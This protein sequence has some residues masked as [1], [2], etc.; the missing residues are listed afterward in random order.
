MNYYDLIRG[1]AFKKGILTDGDVKTQYV[2]LQEEAGELADALLKNDKEEIKDAVG[3]I[4]VVLVS[5]SELAGFP[6]EEA[7]K[8]AWETIKNR[9]GTMQNGTF[10]KKK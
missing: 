7:V 6:I 10:V 4:I 2:K 5:F 9:E 8:K 1:W 3:D